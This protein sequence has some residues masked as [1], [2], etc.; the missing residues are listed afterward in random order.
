VWQVLF[1]GLAF[2]T[3]VL[4]IANFAARNRKPESEIKY[5]WLVYA[6]GVPSAA[7]GIL[8]LVVG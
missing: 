2:L 4:L 8:F 3:Q 6:I 1:V 7:L 5:G